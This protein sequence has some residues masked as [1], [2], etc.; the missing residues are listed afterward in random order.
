MKSKLIPLFAIDHRVISPV[1]THYPRGYSENE[2]ANLVADHHG[3]MFPPDVEQVMTGRCVALA[4]TI[5][6]K[7]YK[8]FIQRT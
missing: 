2:L 8:T 4:R 3:I 7:I 6:W 1:G 5:A